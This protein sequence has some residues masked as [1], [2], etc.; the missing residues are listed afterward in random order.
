VGARR[1]LRFLRRRQERLDELASDERPEIVD[2]FADADES[3][4][5]GGLAMAPPPPLA[6][7]SAW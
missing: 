3:V 2:A 1:S 4:G 6:L 7:P 5:P